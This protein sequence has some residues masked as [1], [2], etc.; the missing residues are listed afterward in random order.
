MSWWRR[1]QGAEGGEEA[2]APGKSSLVDLTLDTA[3]GSPFHSG[4]R[5]VGLGAQSLDSPPA[6]QWEDGAI[7]KMKG[8]KK[9]FRAL[10]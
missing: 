2:L 3:V 4:H 1:A 6:R 5:R 10:C 8:E 9:N 7:W